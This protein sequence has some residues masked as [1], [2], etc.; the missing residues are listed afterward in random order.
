MKILIVD[1][2]PEERERVSAFAKSL[3]HEVRAAKDGIA[4][5][6][7]LADE[8]ASVL[9]T[10]LRMPRMDGM[11]LIQELRD[12]GSQIPTIVLTGFGSIEIALSLVQ[13]L[14]A[15]WF[16]EKPVDAKSLHALL[17]RLDTHTRLQNEVRELRRQLSFQGVLGDMAGQSAPMREVFTL[18]RQVAPTNVP[19]LITGESGTGKELAA[20][21]MHTLSDRRAHP[22]V[23][24]NCAALPETL[25]ESELFGHEKGSFTGAVDRRIGCMEMAEGGTLFLDEISEMPIAVQPKLLRVLEDLRF[26]R[27]GGRQELQADLRILAATN[28]DPAAAIASGHLRPDLFYRL[29]VFQLRLPAL[30]ERLDDIPILATDIIRR[31]NER[32]G[33]RV[34][35]VHSSALL[36][37]ESR[38]WEGNV[39]EFRNVLERAVILAGNGLLYPQH[40][41]NAPAPPANRG[42]AENGLNIRLGS[43]LDEAER[44]LIDATLKKTGGNKTKAAAVLGISAK[45]LH[46]KL[47][48]YRE[49]SLT[50]GSGA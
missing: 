24:V 16:L 35:G 8:S 43:T 10:D 48:Q 27:I 30:R 47:R 36:F 22:F 23:A 50:P 15:F 18:I 40:F 42:T 5:M 6:E 4:A 38:A 49:Q 12:Q 39:R 20:R 46:V 34:T 11:Q 9:I 29:S 14:G 31:L 44:T 13:D 2:D 7:R 32:H 37:L 1:D 28:R 45:T 25:I 41:A 26:R 21:A 33:T 19:V 17:E 3:G